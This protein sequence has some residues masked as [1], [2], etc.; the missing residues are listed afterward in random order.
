V[1][2]PSQTDREQWFPPAPAVVTPTEADRKRQCKDPNVWA[3]RSIEK[4]RRNLPIS[5]AKGTRRGLMQPQQGAQ[6]HP[7][8]PTL[9]QWGTQ[10]VPVNCGPNWDWDVIEHAVARGPHRSALDPENAATVQEDVQYQ[11][12]AGF[13][14]IFTWEEVQRLR[15][16]K[17]KVSPMAVVRQKNRRERI[18]LDLSFPV[19]P[20]CAGKSTQ[21]LTHSK[22]ASMRQPNA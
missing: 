12:D 8:Y 15:P 11:V 16:T 10:G 13:L 6:N 19:Y 7:F 17:L 1:L 5:Q 14:E 2:L 22:S 4:E 3:P 9:K 21:D 20:A 18:I